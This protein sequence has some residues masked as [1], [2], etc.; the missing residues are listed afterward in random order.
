M[1]PIQDAAAV[2]KLANTH[3]IRDRFDT[4]ELAFRGFQYQKGELICSPINPAE[5]IFFL[6]EGSVQLYDLRPDGRKLPVASVSEDVVIGDMEFVTG[7]PTTFFV[8]AAE[9]CVCLALPV[10]PYREALEKD[11]RFL[12]SL[13]D[14]M[15][16]KFERDADAGI[17]SANLD[18]RVLEYLRGKV[19]THEITEVETLL[20]QLRCS[21]RQLQR[22]LKKLCEEGQLEHLG[23][24]HY[25]LTEEK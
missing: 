1:K 5:Y 19:P 24:G 3:H 7:R 23:K 12:H 6:I 9:D 2:E 17:S 18:E 4:P 21:R 10:A 15:A 20:Y 14:D 11:V 25:R 22:A 8:E 16:E 13:L